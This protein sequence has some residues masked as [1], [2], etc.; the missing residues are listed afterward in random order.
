MDR[1][2]IHKALAQHKWRPTYVEDLLEKPPPTTGTRV[3]STKTLADVVEA[4]IGASYVSGGMPK[5]LACMSLFLP[6]VEWQS[7]EHGREVLYGEA[8]DDEALPPTMRLLEPLV[9]YTFTKKALLVEAMTHP[10]CNGPGVRASLDRLEFL[11]DAILDYIVVKTLFDVADPAPL[12]NVTLHLLRT[13]LVNADILGFLVMEWSIQQ[14]RID[15]VS[16]PSRNNNNSSSSSTSSNISSDNDDEGY[17]S[18]SSPF[19]NNSSNSSNSNNNSKDRIHLVPAQTTFPLWSFMR[20][21]SP[22]M[23]LIQRAT[24]QR[25]AA[26]RAG[27]GEALGSG[28]AYPWAALTRLQPQKFYSDVLESLL[29][30]VWVDSGSLAA[31][32]A[33]LERVGLLRLARRLVRDRVRLMHP[34]EELGM[35][36]AGE[37]VEYVV[38]A[39]T[40]TASHDHH[41]HRHH[42]PEVVFEGE[43]DGDGILGGDGGG[44]SGGGSPAEEQFVCRVLVGGECVAEVG[45]ALW[46]EE[47]RTRAAEVACRVLRERK[48]KKG[49][50]GEGEREEKGENGVGD[51]E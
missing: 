26:M 20:H 21:A 18:S 4:L 28:D 24:A 36:A 41:H 35:V 39:A 47:A 51:S 34:K 3:L 17:S 45:G 32:E 40:T 5:A 7:I 9:G 10:S 15:V 42:I 6:E 23:G 14:E 37:T 48:G 31:C 44:G 1:Y 25:H 13:A 29:G 38:T 46:R 8:P 30:A 27:I 12:D 49:G 33:V 11:G 43:V 22:D 50:E 19:S 16:E 2:I